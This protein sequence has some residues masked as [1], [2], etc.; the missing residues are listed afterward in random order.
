M[1]D[2]CWHFFTSKKFWFHHT[3]SLRTVRMAILNISL[4]VHKNVLPS[5]QWFRFKFC[6]DANDNSL[7]TVHYVLVLRKWS[8]L[9]P[10]KEFRCFVKNNRIIGR[11]ICSEKLF[12]FIWFLA[13]TQ[14][15][16]ENYYDFIEPIAE[17]IMND[18]NDFFI[19]HI[20]YKFPSTDFVVDIYRKD[21]VRTFL[22]LDNSTIDLLRLLLF[23]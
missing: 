6:Y 5:F 13:I 10:S 17:Q 8:A 21:V 16:S 9:Q 4:I 14:R 7:S 1:H 19:A 22:L 23:L 3:W 15:D 20:Q 12:S 18:I 11:F 2:N